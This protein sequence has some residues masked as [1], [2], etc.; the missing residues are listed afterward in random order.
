[1]ID[2]EPIREQDLSTKT[3]PFTIPSPRKAYVSESQQPSVL[4]IK[5]L[6]NGAEHKMQRLPVE[7]DYWG[8]EPE[9][10][11]EKQ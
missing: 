5:M 8:V 1:V 3:A 9:G 10:S 6:S 7:W 2:Q 4:P 11:K